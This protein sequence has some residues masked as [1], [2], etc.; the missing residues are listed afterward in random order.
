MEQTLQLDF[1][2][3]GPTT[4]RQGPLEPQSVTGRN[5]GGNTEGF[6]SIGAGV[7][8]WTEKKCHRLFWGEST[9]GR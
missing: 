4:A 6:N 8:V 7:S 3:Q 2:E 9:L 5:I 1:I